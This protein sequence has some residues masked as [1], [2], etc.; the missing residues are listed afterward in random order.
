MK[1]NEKCF[2]GFISVICLSITVI[3]FITYKLGHLINFK[4]FFDPDN[5]IL[6]TDKLGHFGD[7]IGGFLGTILTGFATYFVYKTY[8]SQKEEL[9]D[10]KKELSLHR[11]LI[12][13]QQF[14]ST[15]FNMLTVHRELK[16]EFE[17]NINTR[18][19]SLSPV[20]G[21]NENDQTSPRFNDF[22]FVNINDFKGLDVLNFIRKDFE[23]LFK[24]FKDLN[25]PVKSITFG[26]NI[27]KNEVS[28]NLKSNKK[29]LNKKE[30]DI[31]EFIF[32]IVFSNYRNILSHYFR[33]VYHIL[34]FVKENE[35]QNKIIYQ[36][37]TDI[38]Q[39]Q[40]NDD[41]QFLLFYY[42]IVM[43]DKSK[44]QFSTIEICNSYRF[45]ENLGN[46]NL[47]DNNLHNNKFFYSFNII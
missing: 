5:Y 12:V 7:F 44:K 24:S 16:K 25:D 37:Y 1:K 43:N 36:K 2:I 15:F 35:I 17:I 34:K 22:K 19:T 38:F 6:Y 42:F 23:I 40:L 28:Q 31:I 21:E 9:A 26:G 10:Q 30:E 45:L 18:I 8:I 32:L 33:N 47:L 4:Y 14:E 11:Q 27:L 29:V 3:T 39:S 41:E 13:Q 46:E 20:R